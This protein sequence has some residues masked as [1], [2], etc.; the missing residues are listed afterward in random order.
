MASNEITRRELDVALRTYTESTI[1]GAV[2]AGGSNVSGLS[3]GNY[4][5][6]AH[7]LFTPDVIYEGDQ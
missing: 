6:Y 4:A 3:L 1:T 2:L 7:T 5:K